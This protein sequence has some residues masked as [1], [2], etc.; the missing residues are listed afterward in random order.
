[1]DED[2]NLISSS[3]VA[4]SHDVAFVIGMCISIIIVMLAL[5]F[6]RLC[7]SLYY[8]IFN[9]FIFCSSQLLQSALYGSC[10]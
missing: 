8:C 3:D 1:M 7:K 6:K 4:S 9:T 5:L 10:G 2:K